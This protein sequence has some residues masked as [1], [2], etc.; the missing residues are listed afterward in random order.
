MKRRAAPPPGL[1]CRVCGCEAARAIGSV[2]FYSGYDWSIFDC[3]WCGCRF[4]PHDP[5]FYEQLHGDPGSSYVRYRLLLDECRALFQAGDLPGLRARLAGASKYA[6][7]CDAV[8]RLPAGSKILEV[9]CS[10]G[11]LTSYGILAGHDILGVDVSTEALAAAREAFGG[12]F[13]S[14]ESPGMKNAAPYD[15][16]YHVGTI[17]CVADPLG[18]TRDLLAMLKPEGRLVFNAPNRLCCNLR[19]QLWLESAPPPDVVTLFSPSFWNRQMARDAVV[20]E[21]LD[22]LAPDRS[23]SRWLRKRL[24]WQWQKPAVLPVGGS[25]VSFEPP[26]GAHRSIQHFIERVAAKFCRVSGLL[27]LVPSQP[28][29]FGLFVT[30]SRK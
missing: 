23:L 26:A 12:H 17:G 19:G 15:L 9:G 1:P 8:D 27:Q 14:V 3:A 22:M 4:T 2:E 16:I 24:G 7:V 25:H 11:Y 28:D 13:E 18:L 21:K 29:D 20:S 30:M 10:R 5:A 6:L